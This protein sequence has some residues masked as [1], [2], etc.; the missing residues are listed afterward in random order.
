MFVVILFRDEASAP[1]IDEV[2]IPEEIT[3]ETPRSAFD[4]INKWY[5]DNYGTVSIPTFIELEG[6]IYS[7]DL[8]KDS[9]V[10]NLVL[11]DDKKTLYELNFE[12]LA[13][14]YIN[15]AYLIEDEFIFFNITLEKDFECSDTDDKEICV[16]LANRIL[17]IWY[18]DFTTGE[19]SSVARLAIVE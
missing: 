18:Y 13:E 14:L 8:E 11:K 16:N 19:V 2:D 9:D 1:V 5:K 4:L 3:D 15:D 12:S 10:Y 7:I 17:G 6:S